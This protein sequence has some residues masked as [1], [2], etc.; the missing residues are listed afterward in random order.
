MYSLE[1]ILNLLEQSK[2]RNWYENK[3]RYLNEEENWDEI[4][5]DLKEFLTVT[6]KELKDFNRSVDKIQGK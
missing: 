5:E 6:Q 3:F 1:E 2:F 4:V